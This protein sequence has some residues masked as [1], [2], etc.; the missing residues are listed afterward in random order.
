MEFMYVLISGN[1]E[2][3]VLILGMEYLRLHSFIP[4]ELVSVGT[5]FR[6]ILSI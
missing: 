5:D 6:Q 2:M 4:V 1:D 3:H